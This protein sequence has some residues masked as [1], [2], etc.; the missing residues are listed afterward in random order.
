MMFIIN[1]KREYTNRL[2]DVKNKSQQNNTR[3][4]TNFI[5]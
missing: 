4:I 3:V 1:A 5:D 2:V